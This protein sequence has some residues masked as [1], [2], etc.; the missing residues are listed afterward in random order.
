MTIKRMDHVSIVVDDLPAAMAF[1]TALGMAL[2]GEMPVEGDWVDR[3]CGLKGVRVDIAMMRT[4]DG[5]GRVELTKFRSPEL[6]G[7]E[8]AAAPP[9][10]LGLRQIMFA[11][12]DI[13]DTMRRLRGHGAELIGEVA[14]YE[15]RY[16]LCYLRGPVG[17][18]VA[19]A[20]ELF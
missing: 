7:A 12:E 17:I 20:E 11:V 16:R 13:D 5:H 15:E 1:F 19:L 8:P 10:T 18:I 6:A 14:Q 4:P 9:N 3:V 2:E